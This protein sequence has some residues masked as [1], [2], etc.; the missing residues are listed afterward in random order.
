MQH[1]LDNPIYHALTTGN[2]PISN[3]DG[4]VRFLDPEIGAFA[5]LENNSVDQLLELYDLVGDSVPVVLFTPREIG[6]PDRWKIVLSKP[7]MQMVWQGGPTCGY[8][9]AVVPL[10]GANVPEMLDLTMRTKPG[11]FLSR[12]IEFGHYEGIFRDG[13]LV[14][15]AGQ[16]LHPSPF[17][18]ISAVCTDPAYLGKGFAGILIRNQIC[19]MTAAGSIPFLHVL[20]ENASARSLYQKLGF[21]DRA[22]MMY[23]VLIRQP[24]SC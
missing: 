4:S 10:T 14:S 2:E 21:R 22:E 9:P 19:R 1:I 6:I 12:T 18:E 11:P 13:R 5:G 7:L 16:R 20:P 23:Y 15:M 8:D 24:V 3:G 17:A